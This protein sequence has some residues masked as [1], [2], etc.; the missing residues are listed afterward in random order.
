MSIEQWL[1]QYGYWALFFGVI[2]EGPITLTL[3]GFLAHQGYLNLWAVLAV[4]G[5]ASFLVIEIAYLVGLRAGE[6]LIARW[7]IWRR[8]HARFTTLM[9][10][11]KAFFMVG[12]RFLA[13][14]HSVIPAA[15]GMAGVRPA[16]FS[17]MNAIGAA[18]WTL[19]YFPLGYFF[20]HAFETCVAD[21]KLHEKTL[22]LVL[23]AA[24]LTLYLLRRVIARRSAGRQAGAG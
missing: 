13:G 23:V 24:M 4:A 7:P 15:I 22:G 5:T 3:A 1:D 17:A 8:N 11:Y 20:G 19:I 14:S 21:I 10:R 9:A 12:F 6:Y 16:Y 2:L 18:L